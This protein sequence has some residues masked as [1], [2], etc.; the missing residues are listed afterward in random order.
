M[1]YSIDAQS[2]TGFNQEAD[3]GTP[4]L[5]AA[6]INYSRPSRPGRRMGQERLEGWLDGV[7]WPYAPAA[8]DDMAG[9]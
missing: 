1:R 2:S 6:E 7:E 5:P 3:V 9:A 4:P 8:E